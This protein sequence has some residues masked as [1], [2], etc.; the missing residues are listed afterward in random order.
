MIAIKVPAR[1]CFFG[2]HQD[3]LGLPVIAGTVNRYICLRAVPIE[4]KEFSVV[5]KDLQQEFVIPLSGKSEKIRGKDYFRSGISILKDEGFQFSQ[6]YHI[7]IWGDIPINAGLSS[8]SALVVAW[9]R[10]LVAVQPRKKPISDLQ[11]ARWAHQAEVLFFNQPGG[12]MD[13]YTIA[14]GGM[15]YIDTNTGE[16]TR[17]KNGLGRLL[18]AESGLPK[19]TL[20][21]LKNAREYAQ[22]AISSIRSVHPEFDLNS[23]SPEDYNRYLEIVPD[24]YQE[25]WYASVHNYQITKAAKEEL[26][27]WNPDLKKLAGLMNEHQLILQSRIQNTPTEMTQMMEAAKQAG[28]LACKIIGSGGGG[29]MLALVGNNNIEKIKKAFLET[30]A[31]AV[32]E[33][34]IGN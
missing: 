23:V 22:N 1:I 8:S 5:L 20:S 34:E 4:R 28:A 17:L 33:V 31:K 6:G 15:L 11:I 21:V 3:Y 9:I 10:F 27:Y 18:V 32:Y 2:D 30:R 12:L 24:Q 13:Q 16:S 7:E 25:H 29:C 14:Q 26:L 19:K